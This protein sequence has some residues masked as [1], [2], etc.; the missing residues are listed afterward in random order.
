MYHVPSPVLGAEDARVKQ[1]KKSIMEL[2]YSEVYGVLGNQ[3]GY[4]ETG[5]ERQGRA[6][7]DFK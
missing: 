5:R 7:R 4:G 3:K 1:K 6:K 2:T